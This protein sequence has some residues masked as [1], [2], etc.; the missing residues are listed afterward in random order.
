MVTYC[1]SPKCIMV[2]LSP[3]DIINLRNLVSSCLKITERSLWQDI[4]VDIYPAGSHCM[5]LIARPASPKRRRVNSTSP[6]H[7]RRRHGKK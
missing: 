6:R 1:I 7:A 4:D 3:D 2:I 5:M